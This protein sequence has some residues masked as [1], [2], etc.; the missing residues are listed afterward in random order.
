MVRA[1][2][3]VRCSH[4]VLEVPRCQK[5]SVESE[6]R[7]YLQQRKVSTNAFTQYPDD[8][9]K[10]SGIEQAQHPFWIW[11]DSR[12][13]HLPVRENTSKLTVFEGALET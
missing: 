6:V 8:K 3:A 2:E 9:K 5:S 10:K 7:Y 1:P 13:V 11:A 12:V 4:A